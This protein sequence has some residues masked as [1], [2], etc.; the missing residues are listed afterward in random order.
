M[1]LV[2][3]QLYSQDCRQ[4]ETWKKQ[5]HNKKTKKCGEKMQHT[6]EILRHETTMNGF[7]YQNISFINIKG[8]RNQVEREVEE[9]ISWSNQMKFKQYTIT[10]FSVSWAHSTT[11]LSQ[12][13]YV[14]H[15]TN[16]FWNGWKA[17][18]DLNVL[19]TGRLTDDCIITRVR[20]Y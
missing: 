9:K 5:E 11:E 8:D 7:N 6:P 15:L 18:L 2:K 14:D 17:A 19:Y 12:G 3:R 4:S 1:C 20:F 10:A 13:W 16:C